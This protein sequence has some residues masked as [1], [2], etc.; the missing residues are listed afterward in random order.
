MYKRQGFA[1]LW[2]G[3]TAAPWRG[4]GIYRAMVA[5][6]AGLAAELGYRY[7]QVDATDD[8]APILRR[9]GFSALST[10]TPYVY[11]ATR[12]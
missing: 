4:M 1:G 9:L 12:Q 8:S 10:T 11:R 3:G 2:G 7:L 5:H 6:R